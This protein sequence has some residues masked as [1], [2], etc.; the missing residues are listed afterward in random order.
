MYYIT[1]NDLINDYILSFNPVLPY[2]DIKYISKKYDV[3]IDDITDYYIV[4][5]RNNRFIF[6]SYGRDTTLIRNRKKICIMDLE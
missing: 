2:E 4:Y 1:I 5:Y 3:H 6:V